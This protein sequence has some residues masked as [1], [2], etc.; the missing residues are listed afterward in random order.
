[1]NL[2]TSAVFAALCV[3]ET[4]NKDIPGDGG[5]SVGVAQIQ[6]VRAIDYNKDHPGEEITLADCRRPEIAYKVFVW[7]VTKF[8]PRNLQD[9][10]AVWNHPYGGR[11]KIRR[12]PNCWLAK[13]CRQF[14]TL[15][16]KGGVR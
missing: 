2:A 5:K 14:E 10:Y 3:F 16:K 11:A 4:G 8:K 6:E 1:M 9:L 13:R 7:T 15:V 12:Y